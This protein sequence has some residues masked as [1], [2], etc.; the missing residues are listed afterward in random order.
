M[1]REPGRLRGFLST[2]VSVP[3]HKKAL[4]ISSFCVCQA[5]Q[6]LER[7]IL[8]EKNDIWKRRS[9]LTHS[10]FKLIQLA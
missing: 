9:R 1:T 3:P 5:Q 7:T 4:S 8:F 2:R 6:S 10:G